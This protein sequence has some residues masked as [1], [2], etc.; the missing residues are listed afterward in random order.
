MGNHL[1]MGNMCEGPAKAPLENHELFPKKLPYDYM[2]KINERTVVHEKWRM[3]TWEEFKYCDSML[4]TEEEFPVDIKIAVEGGWF[5]RIKEGE[6][7]RLNMRKESEEKEAGKED[8]YKA[9]Y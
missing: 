8:E 6:A 5:E 3:A 4:A 1:I 2:Y 7:N 9:T